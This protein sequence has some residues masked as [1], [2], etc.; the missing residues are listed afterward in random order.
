[1]T[2]FFFF[3]WIYFHVYV[4]YLSCCYSSNIITSCRIW[5]FSGLYCFSLAWKTP[6]LKGYPRRL[7]RQKHISF[8]ALRTPFK[9]WGLWELLFPGFSSYPLQSGRICT[10]YSLLW[11]RTNLPPFEFCSFGFTWIILLATIIIF[12]WSVITALGTIFQLPNL[13]VKKEN[14]R[15]RSLCA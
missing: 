12:V 2:S 11:F 1:M 15:M 10:E 9:K 14:K 5:L 13:S 6:S 3:F 4:P 8:A 7:Q